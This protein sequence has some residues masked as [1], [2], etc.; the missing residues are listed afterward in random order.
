MTFSFAL[1]AFLMGLAGGPHCIAM[2][3]GACA[4]IKQNQKSN[5]Q[6]I[7]FQLGRIIGY[8]SMGAIAAASVKSLAWFSSQTS[9][10]H[11]L[12]TFFH[13]L[14]LAWGLMLLIFARQPAWADSIGRSVWDKLRLSTASAKSMLMMGMMWAL[15]PC[16]LL[17]SALLIASLQASPVNGAV[18]M[19]SFA[20]GT[21]LTLFFGPILWLKLKSGVKWMTEANSMRLA[22]LLLCFVSAT[23][24]WMD[25]VH[26]NKI[27]CN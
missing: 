15:M 18:S 3:G 21:S 2:C 22:G 23:A 4:Y 5:T 17:Y 9:A 8:A 14:V 25:V 12:W 26:Q 20:L 10:L 6:Y 11:P 16:G 19:A 7:V 24:I 1:A 13:A 27:W